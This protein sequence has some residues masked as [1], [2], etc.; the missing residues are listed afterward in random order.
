MTIF[1]IGAN[2]GYYTLLAESLVGPEGRVF[3]FE[4]HPENYEKLKENI[5]VNGYTNCY[6]I[7]KAVSD[8]S[9]IIGI[10]FAF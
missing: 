10:L 2:I 4:P 1:D 6:L 9:G 3:A 8:K 7:N 5:E